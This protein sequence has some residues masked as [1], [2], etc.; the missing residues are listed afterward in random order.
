MYCKY[1]VSFLDNENC[2][3]F[4]HPTYTETCWYDGAKHYRYRGQCANCPNLNNWTGGINLWIDDI[5]PAPEGFIWLKSVKEAIDFIWAYNATHTWGDGF[6]NIVS[7]DHDAGDYAS[8]GGDYIKI[9]DWIEQHKNSI[10]IPR[11]FHLHTMNT[12]GYVNMKRII[13]HNNW[14]FIYDL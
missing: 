7:L 4:D 13:T 2:D 9:L 5:R 10:N 1:F 3:I 6:I 14:S 12:V 8:D 11:H